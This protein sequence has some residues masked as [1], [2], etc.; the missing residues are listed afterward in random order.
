MGPSVAIQ[1]DDL[2]VGLLAILADVER[3][4]GSQIDLDADYYWHIPTEAAFDIGSNPVPVVGQLSD[5][6]EE[7]ARIED[8]RLIVVVVTIGHRRDPYR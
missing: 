3:K 1:I 5:D 2:R 4:F 7:L 8:D 6:I